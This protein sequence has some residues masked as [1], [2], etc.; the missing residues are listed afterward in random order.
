MAMN[1]GNIDCK[2]KYFFRISKEKTIKDVDW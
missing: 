1:K 2:V